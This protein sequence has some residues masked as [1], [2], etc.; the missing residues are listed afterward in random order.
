MTAIGSADAGDA[1][2]AGDV[3]D[4]GDAGSS[5]SGRGVSA[6]SPVIRPIGVS[7]AL[8]QNQGEGFFRGNKW[9][10][11]DL[12]WQN[13]DAPPPPW[14]YTAAA[15]FPRR[16]WAGRYL[17]IAV[18][19]EFVSAQA[20]D[21]DTGAPFRWDQISLPDWRTNDVAAELFEL[22]QMI[23]YRPGV[24]AEAVNE[25]QGIEVY[26]QGLL[27][28][29]RASHPATTDLMHIAVRV[30]EFQAM[31][32]KHY[33]LDA[34]KNPIPD[35]PRPSQLSPALMPPIAVPGHA[36]YPSGHSTQAHLL[37]GLLAHVMPQA[38]TAPLPVNANPALPDT[39]LLDRLAERVARNR[40]VLGLHYPSD[41]A[42]GK[43][44]AEMSLRILLQCLTVKALIADTA[45]EWA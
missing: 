45:Q 43:R 42:A 7:P 15:S 36:S 23:D 25:I 32:Y 24:M 18:L 27:M 1:G 19:G 3:A 6:A 21:P 4:A 39:S 12:V 17:S 40:E 22:Y 33:L 2:D 10:P 41:S 35:R 13:P 38:V 9:P 31:H 20:N 44:L 29:S 34:A 16:A 14:A 8:R 37:S 5:G 28:S 30:G 26:W 11:A